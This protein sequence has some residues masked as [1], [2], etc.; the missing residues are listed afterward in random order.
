MI[1]YTLLILAFAIACAIFYN[2]LEYFFGDTWVT[3]GIFC[4]VLIALRAG[5]YFYRRSKGI[6][7]SWPND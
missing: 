4:V 3:V 2:T 6:K 1:K 5:L 7:D